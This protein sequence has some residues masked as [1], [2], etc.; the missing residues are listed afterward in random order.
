MLIIIKFYL[1]FILKK[2]KKKNQRKI[3]TKKFLFFFNIKFNL[4]ANFLFEQ[5][6]QFQIIEEIK[7]L[8][9]ELNLLFQITLITKIHE[10]L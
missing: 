7:K 1:G 9:I 8:I 2:K 5:K 10:I 4:P 6:K 3:W